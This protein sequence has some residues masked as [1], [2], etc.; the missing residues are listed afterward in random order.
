MQSPLWFYSLDHSGAGEVQQQA[1]EHAQ[2]DAGEGGDHP[3]AAA[4]GELAGHI[5]PAQA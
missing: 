1:E 4:L 2:G 3:Q 5:Q